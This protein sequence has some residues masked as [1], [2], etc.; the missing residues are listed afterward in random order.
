MTM[1]IAAK[2]EL[3]GVSG[4]GRGGLPTE[5]FAMEKKSPS[6]RPPSLEPTLQ[7]L[8]SARRLSLRQVDRWNMLRKD[9]SKL[10]GAASHK[11]APWRWYAISFLRTK[12]IQRATETA[13]GCSQS[14]EGFGADPGVSE[15]AVPGARATTGR[16]EGTHRLGP[17]AIGGPICRV[18]RPS[19]TADI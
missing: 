18:W 10:S 9:S 1:L 6:G 3:N 5:E 13:I 11:S 2:Y 8:L 12:S 7:I 19:R 15:P 14:A 17:G 4:D 16:P